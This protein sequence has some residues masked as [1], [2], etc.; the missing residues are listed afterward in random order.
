M[1]VVDE[2]LRGRF[3]RTTS[4][5]IKGRGTHDLLCYVRDS[6]GNDAQGTEFC[7]TFD[8]RKFL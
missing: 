6:I 3:I 1:K 7:Y 4:A 2:H 8:I 5:S